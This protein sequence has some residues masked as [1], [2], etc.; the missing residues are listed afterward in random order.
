MICVCTGSKRRTSMDGQQTILRSDAGGRLPPSTAEGHRRGR[1]Y[2]YEGI[3][4]GI[5]LYQECIIE[6]V[7]TACTLETLM[8]R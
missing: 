8:Y 2:H 3:H 7:Y 6:Q 5:Y 4:A 1:C